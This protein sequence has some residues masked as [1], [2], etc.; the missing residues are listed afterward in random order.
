MALF[1]NWLGNKGSDSVF[2]E[3]SKRGEQRAEQLLQKTAKKREEIENQ[4]SEYVRQLQ[5]QYHQSQLQQ[6]M[7][8]AQQTMAQNITNNL[9]SGL[10]NQQTVIDP[11]HSGIGAI[12]T[13]NSGGY[14]Y[15]STVTTTTGGTLAGWNP[16]PGA[17]TPV[18]TGSIPPQ[19]MNVPG[20]IYSQPGGGV[21]HHMPPITPM[22]VI[23]TPKKGDKVEFEFDG[24]TWVVRS[25][26]YVAAGFERHHVK[27]EFSLDELDEA[28][29][30]IEQLNVKGKEIVQENV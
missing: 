20:A 26:K 21:H 22:A 8:K 11:G 28:Q 3:L 29:K 10:A 9:Y 13:I 1:K 15:P 18:S 24:N 27:G 5:N 25:E 4:R 23:P 30:I 7:I 19:W 12:G 17:I 6:D 14:W 2:D 16:A